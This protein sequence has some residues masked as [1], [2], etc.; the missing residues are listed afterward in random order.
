MITTTLSKYLLQC[1]FFNNVNVVSH[2]KVYDTTAT[3]TV[4]CDYPA[5]YHTCI[6]DMLICMSNIHGVPWAHCGTHII[7]NSVSDS[8]YDTRVQHL[9]G[10]N[11]N[12]YD[13][14]A[15]ALVSW[16]LLWSIHHGPYTMGP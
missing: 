10:V 11:K 7:Y 3:T 13:Q 12:F 4:Q 5:L 14:Q 16:I 9:G 15:A 1:Y 6:I 8:G 2:N